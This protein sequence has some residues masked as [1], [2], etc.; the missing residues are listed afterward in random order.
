M[1]SLNMVGDHDLATANPGFDH[2]RLAARDPVETGLFFSCVDHETHHGK[3]TFRWRRSSG[4][5]KAFPV[6]IATR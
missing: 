2:A 5:V 1:H 4:N 6:D 3:L